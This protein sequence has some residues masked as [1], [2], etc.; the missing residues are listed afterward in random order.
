MTPHLLDALV[1]AMIVLPP[2]IDRWIDHRY[3]LSQR[4]RREP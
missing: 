3:H 4:W 2:K 1:L